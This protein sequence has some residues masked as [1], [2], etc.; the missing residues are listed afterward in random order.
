[1]DLCYSDALRAK[2]EENWKRVSEDNLDA[3]PDIR[4]DLFK[5]MVNSTSISYRSFQNKMRKELV[6]SFEARIA[7]VTT[8]KDLEPSFIMKANYQEQI[9]TLNK[10]LN[11]LFEDRRQKILQDGTQNEVLLLRIF[12]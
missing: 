6:E 4:W 1:M 2:L 9:N 10:D 5:C 11:S 8:L 12:S 3:K 7:N